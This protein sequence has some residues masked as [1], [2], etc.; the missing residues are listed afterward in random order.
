MMTTNQE[1][2]HPTLDGAQMQSA[3]IQ[4]LTAEQLENF[5]RIV[6]E[7]GTARDHAMFT[8]IYHLALRASEAAELKLSQ[9]DW[10]T[11]QVFVIAKK[12]GI[13][14]SLRII[15]VKGK[16]HLDMEKA[17]KRYMV[18]RKLNN[19]PSDFLFASQKGGDL[20]PLSINRIYKK[21]FD[22]TNADRLSKDLAAIPEEV[23][24][25]HALRHTFCTLAAEA[26]MSIYHIAQIARHRS[27]NSTMKYAHGSPAL[28]S[29]T[30]ERKVYEVHQ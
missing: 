25:V 2:K 11:K 5:L 30:W 13:N 10:R 26:G 15:A 17:L 20:N 27:L 29:Q 14:S 24:H 4:H 9:V 12:D 16:P 19:E 8:T 3:A 1:Q 23:G 18:E 21:Y 7:Q 28:A 6:F 22:L